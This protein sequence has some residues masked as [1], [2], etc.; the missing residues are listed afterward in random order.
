MATLED[1]SIDKVN[2]RKC[3]GLVTK[4]R[5]EATEQ[6]WENPGWVEEMLGLWRDSLWSRVKP[7]D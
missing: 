6:E 5:A 1:E 3:L 4:A 2:R 7:A